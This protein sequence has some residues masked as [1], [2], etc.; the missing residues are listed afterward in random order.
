MPAI[1]ESYQE[2]FNI[3]DDTAVKMTKLTEGYAYAYQVLGYLMWNEQNK[4]ISKKILIQFD[5]YLAEFVYDKIWEGLS[6]KEK[7]ILIK[8][9][10]SEELGMKPSELSVYRDRL[11]KYGVLTSKQRGKLSFAL[12]RFKEYIDNKLLFE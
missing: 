11:I 7:S 6:E 10:K 9:S 5:Q 1:K 12:P 4:K 8:I 2:I 3:D